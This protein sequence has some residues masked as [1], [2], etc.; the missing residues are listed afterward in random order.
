MKNWIVRLALQE[1]EE[2]EKLENILKS[3]GWI[4]ETEIL[5]LEEQ[6][7]NRKLPEMNE[8]KKQSHRNLVILTDQPLKVKEAVQAKLPVIYY[9]H[10]G[11]P[12]VYDADMTLLSLEGLD[13]DFFEKVFRRH[14]N[15]PWTIA[16]T[17]R[18][19]IRESTLKDF[20]GLLELYRDDSA[21]RW[22]KDETFCSVNDKQVDSSAR[23]A[24]F[25]AYIRHQYSYYGY[26]LYTVLLKESNT[27]VARIGFG[28]REYWGKVYLDFG[29]LVGRAYRNQGI[30]SE[31]AL[32]LAGGMED[33]TGEKSATIFCH[34][35]NIPSRRTAEKICRLSPA[36]FRLVLIDQ[37]T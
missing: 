2:T 5:C 35:D 6:N 30:A 11:N 18:L 14:Y 26:G 23:S 33:L 8:T 24:G 10:L 37:E 32:A 34:R 20:E 31:T 36:H 19:I 29:Y 7:T 28:N 12:P 21:L 25:A 27:I 22:I 1:N 13:G 3:E 4:I 16:E 15:L 17:E 9:E